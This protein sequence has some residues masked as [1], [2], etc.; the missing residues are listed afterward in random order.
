MEFVYIS[1]NKKKLILNL[2]T[3]IKQI[4][5]QIKEGLDFLIKAKEDIADLNAQRMT[6]YEALNHIE[7]NQKPSNNG[8][9]EDI[10]DYE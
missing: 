6:F 4:D 8:E 7:K 9:I 3:M 10:N 1:M 2:N 5:E